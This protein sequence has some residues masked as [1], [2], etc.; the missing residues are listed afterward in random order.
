MCCSSTYWKLL[1]KSFSASKCR[2][3]TNKGINVQTQVKH[4]TSNAALFHHQ[5][6]FR[7]SERKRWNGWML[8][9]R[10]YV[11]LVHDAPVPL[12]QPGI[13]RWKVKFFC[14][15]KCLHCPFP[16]HQLKVKVST[17]VAVTNMDLSV[18]DKDQSIGTKTTRYMRKWMNPSWPIGELRPDSVT[19][20]ADWMI[21]LQGGLPFQGQEPLHSWQPPELCH[22]LPAGGRQQRCGAHSSPGVHNDLPQTATV[23]L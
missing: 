7:T 23:Q 22:V 8:G 3:W 9:F 19:P 16:R 5:K 1:Q 20:I 14:V 13:T 10:A 15:E 18:V 11:S 17:E 21:V 4:L 12:D 2:Q 6:M